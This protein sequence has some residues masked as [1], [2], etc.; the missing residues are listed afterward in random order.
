[1]TMKEQVLEFI[2]NNAPE[3]YKDKEGSFVNVIIPAIKNLNED[4]I[5]EDI[6]CML[7]AQCKAY[8]ILLDDIAKYGNCALATQCRNDLKKFYSLSTEESKEG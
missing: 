8:D 6:I 3:I 4:T 7:A 1:M 5:F 2:E